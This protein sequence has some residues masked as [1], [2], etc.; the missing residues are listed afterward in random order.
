MIII[1]STEQFQTEYKK[2]QRHF[3]DCELEK[4]SFSDV[5]LSDALFER[6]F[7]PFDFSRANCENTEF[8]ECNLK[9]T[10]FNGA[11]LKNAI[12]QGCSVECMSLKGANIENLVF[13][14]NYSMGCILGQDGLHG[15]L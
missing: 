8:L 12:I 10:D 4:S 7:L 6:C 9:T 11:N 1:T 13:K 5:N 2:G 15:F 3:L 14:D